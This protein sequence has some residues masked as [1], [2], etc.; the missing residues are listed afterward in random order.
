MER[1]SANL[2]EK[3][4]ARPTQTFL[5]SD[6]KK[7]NEEYIEAYRITKQ[8]LVDVPSFFDGRVI[9]EGLLGPVMN[10]GKCGSCWAFAST[11]VLANRFNIQSLGMMN[12]VLSPSKLILCDWQG[13]ELTMS[14]LG[15]TEL[16]STELNIQAFENTACYGNSLLDAFRFLYEIGTPTNE[17]VPYNKMLGNQSEFQ[18][19][20]SF[21]NIADLPLC[22]TVSG[23]IADMCSDF[24][25]NQDTGI[26]SGTPERFYKALHFYTLAGTEKLGGSEL[27][28]RINIYTWGPIATGMQIYPDFYT[29]DPKTDIY[30][31][32]KEGPQVGGHAIELVGWGSENGIDYWIV[33]NSWG[34]EWGMDGYF[35]MKRG[36]DM[37]EIESNCIGVVPDFFFPINYIPNDHEL[38]LEQTNLKAER[39]RIANSLKTTGGGIDLET[40]YSRRVMIS[41]PWLNFQP[42]M[43]W[44]DLPD[45]KTFVAGKDATIYNRTIYQSEI[46][47][48][49]SRI[50]YD[51]ET[52]QIYLYIV[53][54]LLILIVIFTILWIWKN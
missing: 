5:R 39:M 45:W 14:N 18:K 10:Q 30:I 26:E 11:S 32:N 25:I 49:N 9:W 37:C 47:A 4:Q 52:S 15:V 6:D 23:P 35:R 38:L 16:T 2:Q 3:I 8:R 19:I 21:N 29:F 22:H 54:V 41:M 50:Y 1:L 53:I 31:W 51:K 28:I 42:P 36:E 43:K 17:C 20:G 46:R 48:K 34:K 12:V 27:N 40:G 24:Y 7:I 33:K 13:K 44:E